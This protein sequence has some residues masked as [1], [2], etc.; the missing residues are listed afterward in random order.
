VHARRASVLSSPNTQLPHVSSKTLQ[1]GYQLNPPRRERLCFQ[2]SARAHS[3]KRLE[4]ARK[5]TESLGGKMKAFYYTMG[6]Y[7]FVSISEGPDLVVEVRFGRRPSLLSQLT[8]LQSLSENSH[9]RHPYSSLFF[10]ETTQMLILVK[11][12]VWGSMHI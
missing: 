8:R 4:D 12:R 9:N 3:P 6:R 7:D 10:L 5:L 1:G 2:G 11:K